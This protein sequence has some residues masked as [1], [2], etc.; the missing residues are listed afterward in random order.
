MLILAI[1]AQCAWLAGAIL[2]SV[3]RTIRAGDEKGNAIRGAVLLYGLIVAGCFLF[4]VAVPA[5]LLAA[6][7]DSHAV[8]ASFPEAICN[9]PVILFGWGP[10]LIV[11][12][13]ARAMHRLIMHRS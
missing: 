12:V 11:V 5:G 10:A 8:V 9:V 6:G 2:W 4:S 13:S 3:S 1:A 7:A